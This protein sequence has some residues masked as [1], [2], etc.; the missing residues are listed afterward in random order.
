MIE[1]DLNYPH[2]RHATIGP[3]K[4]LFGSACLSAEGG[5]IVLNLTV[6]LT[7]TVSVAA[8][9]ASL[10]LPAQAFEITAEQR[11]ACMGDAVRLC[12]SEL[13]D[14]DRVLVCMRAKKSQVSAHCKA[15]I[16]RSVAQSL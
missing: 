12:G 11:E 14:L 4:R 13:P 7:L 5:C 3:R 1:R 10:T 16:P 8:A 9:A 15:T 6:R 2:N